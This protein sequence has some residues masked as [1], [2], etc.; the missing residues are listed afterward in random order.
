MNNS[1]KKSKE[2]PKD[3]TTLHKTAGE[4]ICPKCG[5]PYKYFSKLK[6]HLDRKNPCVRKEGIKCDYCKKSFA[7][8]YTLEKHI[9]TCKTRLGQKETE[10]DKIVKKRIDAYLEENKKQIPRYHEGGA[11]TVVNGNFVNNIHNGP[12]INV[13]Q[14]T[15]YTKPNVLYLS[16]LPNRIKYVKNVL[17]GPLKIIK[18]V[19]FNEDHPENLTICGTNKKDLVQV[20]DGMQWTYRTKENVSVDVRHRSYN[21][22]EILSMNLPIE[23]AYYKDNV[24]K[25]REAKDNPESI[26]YDIQEID[27]MITKYKTLIEKRKKI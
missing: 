26:E 6:R 19:W 27:G 9:R 2:P 25:L 21:M 13:I 4:F 1:S 10:I 8:K 12:V 24:R 23:L 18:D 16:A 15:P 7:R 3:K 14:L 11:R 20:F 22:A 17:L 5:A